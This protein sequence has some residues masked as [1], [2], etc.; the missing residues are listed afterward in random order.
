MVLKQRHKAGGKYRAI[1]DQRQTFT[2]RVFKRVMEKSGNR[3]QDEL[4]SQGP[5]HK[6]IPQRNGGGEGV[7]D[8]N[9]GIHFSLILSIY[10]CYNYRCMGAMTTRLHVRSMV[11]EYELAI[12]VY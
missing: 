12:L 3:E 4:N 6:K 5:H 10:D 7:G 2:S 11:R 9:R 1:G 8:A